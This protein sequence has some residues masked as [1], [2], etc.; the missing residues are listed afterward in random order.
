MN[1]TLYSPS[2]DTICF[3]LEGLRRE[4]AKQ[5]VSK[6][7][8][9][10]GDYIKRRIRAS[11]PYARK[12]VESSH[13]VPR[14]LE[15]SFVGEKQLEEPRRKLDF[16]RTL[17]IDNYDSYTYNIYQELSVVNGVPPVVVRN[18]E[19]TWED[20][21]HFLYEEDAF[22]NI[23]ISPGPG[24]PAC[25][26]DIGIC[27]QLLLN[28]SDVP[29]LGVCLGHQALGYVHG[30]R[31][32]HAAEP[33]HGRLSEIEHSG[34]KLFDGIPS[35]RN[36][37]FKVVR[38]HSLIIDAESLPKELIPIAWTSSDNKLSSL[39]NNKFD[40][41]PDAYGSQTQHENLDSISGKLKN[42]YNRLSDH[43]NGML[44]RKVLMGVMHASR[45][46]YGV[47]FHPESVATCHG[48]Q[49]FKNFREI[50]EDYWL[51]MR[52]PHINGKNSHYAGAPHRS[53]VQRSS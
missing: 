42:G 44:S 14:H 50:T 53:A 2:P 10:V 52:S 33:V 47:Q 11:Y 23:V 49:I 36:S 34:S 39:G 7:F 18:D 37:G 19:W 25:P 5:V 27:L 45:P 12:A 22:D 41:V 16:V 40:A 24:S 8:L 26:A 9:R 46:H 43:A 32:V 1:F 6:P 20:I 17:L 35:G 31:I 30:A 28:C 38:Y 21:C 4:N 15:R 3:N 48:K 13:L 51:R 29:I